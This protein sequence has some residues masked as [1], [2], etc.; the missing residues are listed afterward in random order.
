MADILSRS[1]R[2]YNMSMI[3]GKDTK[4]EIIL[5]H[6]LHS[7]GFR[8]RKNVKSLPGKPDIVLAKYRTAI[9]VNGCFWHGHKDCEKYV[10]PKT[11]TDFWENKINANRERD[12]MAVQKLESL[13]WNVIIVWECQLSHTNREAMFSAIISKL[14]H[15]NRVWEEYIEQRK[16]NRK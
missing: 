5:R 8:Y 16:W 4:P 11:H 7:K 1:Q 6:Y 9:F 14:E 15:N 12:L 13:G 3:K 10:I 2:H